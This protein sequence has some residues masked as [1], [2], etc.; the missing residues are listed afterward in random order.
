M[1]KLF[2][3]SAVIPPS[4][5]RNAWSVSARLKAT[6]A[7]QGPNT[8]DTT[9]EPTMWPDDPPGIGMLN[10][11]MTKVNAA[12]SARSGSCFSLSVFSAFFEA[13]YQ[14]GAIAMKKTRHVFGLRYPS[15][16]CISDLSG[17]QRTIPIPI[18]R[19]PYLPRSQ[20]R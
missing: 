20:W 8:A 10:I 1:L 15:G 9:T 5:K 7:A 4:P 19:Q 13:R 18:Q 14:T 6:I 17:F 2:A 3:P 16:I 11:I 12:P